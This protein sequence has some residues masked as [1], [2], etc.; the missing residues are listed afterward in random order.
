MRLHEIVRLRGGGGQE[1]AIRDMRRQ[2]SSDETVYT[3]RDKDGNLFERE[4]SELELTGEFEAP[5][6]SYEIVRLKSTRAASQSFAG[7]LGVIRGISVDDESN[8]WGFAIVLQSGECVFMM[9]EELER[10]GH[11]LPEDLQ[12][13]WESGEHVRAGVNPETGE[14]YLMSPGAEADVLRARPLWFRLD[15]FEHFPRV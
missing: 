5:L 15:E 10:T 6:R 1:F 8:A 14:G 3:L 7:E 13:S 12:E 9:D 4:G 2:G 11:V